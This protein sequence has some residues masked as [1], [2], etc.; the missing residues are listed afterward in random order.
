MAYRTSLPG[1][2][3]Q[4]LENWFAL[5]LQQQ[6]ENPNAFAQE[7]PVQAP[8]QLPQNYAMNSSGTVMD[9]GPS[10]PAW[11]GAPKGM[12]LDYANPIEIAGVG[13]GWLA[14]NDPSMTVYD[15]S[16]QP[17]ASLGNDRAA[18]MKLDAGKAQLTHAQ[19][20]N[21]KLIKE[22]NA[23][24]KGMEPKLVDGQWVYP[25][26]SER[27]GGV[28]YPVE[29]FQRKPTAESQKAQAAQ[30]AR[31][32]MGNLLDSM[33]QDYQDLASRG[34]I[35]TPKN[36]TAQNVAARAKGSWLG[37]QIGGAVG[38]EE[39]VIRDKIAMTLPS[40]LNEIR[41]ATA[42]GVT[43]LNTQKELEFY[44]KAATDPSKSLEANL[45]A[46][47]RLRNAYVTPKRVGAV[48]S[49]PTLTQPTGAPAQ[50]L[51]PPEPGRS[52]REQALMKEALD[53][54]QRGAD[55]VAVKQRLQQMGVEL[56]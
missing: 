19:L 39:Q 29:G 7:A 31:D 38:T 32:R 43:Q 35:V 41:L 42:M 15:N 47:N 28:A 20:Q 5:A 56:R 36:T 6:A 53:A 54:I 13:K 9:F 45:D 16:G 2:A 30:E 4:D 48:G 12:Q 10:M 17:I 34:G 33:E 3:Q 26:S 52:P 18:G 21:Q 50:D 51:T 11:A 1:Q 22:I 55:P 8:A 37:Q 46:L 40:I 27:P 14:K 44:A 25:P 49:P 23:Q 24:P